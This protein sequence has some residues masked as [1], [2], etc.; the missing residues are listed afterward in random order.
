MGSSDE[1]LAEAL[2]Q[3]DICFIVTPGPTEKRGELALN[4]ARACKIAGVAFTVVVSVA[5]A[6][7]ED[8]IFGKQFGPMENDFNKL[9]IDG[10]ILRLPMFME[11]AMGN[12]PTITKDGKI[13]APIPIDKK[14][15]TISLNDIAECYIHI[16]KTYLKH[17]KQTYTLYSDTYTNQDVLDGFRKATGKDYIQYVQ[18]PYEGAKQAFQGFGMPEWQAEGVME[19][20]KLVEEGDSTQLTSSFETFSKITG[21]KTTSLAAF[22]EK[23]T[24]MLKGLEIAKPE[25]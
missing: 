19:L 18:V 24:P 23:S 11:N 13:Y 21:H 12:I 1:A 22:F 4:A 20:F 25:P 9:E 2:T 6:D 5:T 10:C 7:K 8:T 15:S 16:A 17:K 14:Y 3:V